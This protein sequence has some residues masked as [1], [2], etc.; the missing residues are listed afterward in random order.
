VLQ[1]F[2]SRYGLSFSGP[3]P[4]TKKLQ[5]LAA[6]IHFSKLRRALLTEYDI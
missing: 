5:Y 1:Y 4:S 2:A 6:L 3:T